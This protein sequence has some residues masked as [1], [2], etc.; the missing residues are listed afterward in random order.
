MLGHLCNRI[1][2]SSRDFIAVAESAM[3]TMKK[4]IE[5]GNDLCII[6]V[7]ELHNDISKV[8]SFLQQP[9]TNLDV[10]KIIEA[11]SEIFDKGSGLTEFHYAMNPQGTQN[12]TAEES[13]N[14]ASAA[15]I[16]PEYMQ[17]KVVEWQGRIAAT[18]AFLSRWYVTGD[19]VQRLLGQTGRTL[20]EQFVMSSDVE[21]VVRQMSYSV[22]ASSIRRPNKERD[23]AN[24]NAF[25]QSPFM[26]TIGEYAGATGNFE[27]LNQLLQTYGDAADMD[28][29]TI[30]LE[31]PE[32]QPDPEQQKIEQEMQMEQQRQEGDMQL[33]QMD[34][35][36]KQQQM[37]LD[38]AKA[39]MDLQM[40]QAEMDFA[41][42]KSAIELQFDQHRH[43]QEMEQDT[44][45]HALDM[46]HQAVA[47]QQKVQQS[48]IEGKHKVDQ[49]RAIGKEKVAATKAMAKAKPKATNGKPKTGA[50]K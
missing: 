3:N 49:Q 47:G 8:I 44:Q 31:A 18:E 40:K 21:D 20:W 16:R 39:Q 15:G 37:E 46:R 13:K 34:M 22:G 27:P 45:R 29:S 35:Q 2:S 36:S 48:F 19:D 41:M 50:K 42:R 10:W 25:M 26:A 28:L 12:R 7:P 5:S 6:P 17:K 24:M 9:Q 4:H 23:V 14:K 38:A 11:V 1:W 32:P 43:E 30:R 33:K